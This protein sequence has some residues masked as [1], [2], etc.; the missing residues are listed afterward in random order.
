MTPKKVWT[1]KRARQEGDP[2][3]KEGNW[4]SEIKQL[5][6]KTMDRKVKVK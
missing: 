3:R 4:H 6:R 2:E 1:E 5:F